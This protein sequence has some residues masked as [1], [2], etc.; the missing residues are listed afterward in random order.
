[1][2]PE[3]YPW[4]LHE[5]LKA[6]ARLAAEPAEQI[7]HLERLGASPSADELALEF[8]EGVLLVPQLVEVGLLTSAEAD[9]LYAL[10]ERLNRLSGPNGPW[11]MDDLRTH[12]AWA[13]IRYQAAAAL[14]LF[15]GKDRYGRTR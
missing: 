15:L 5:L 8:S 1:M 3:H 13:E 10:D 7:A 12:T 14:P 4:A 9:L 2:E 11:H 6:L